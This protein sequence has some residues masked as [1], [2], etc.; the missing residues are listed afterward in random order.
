MLKKMESSE[1]KTAKP[2]WVPDYFID[3]I[4]D[5]NLIQLSKLGVKFVALDADS[6]LV[7]FRSKYLDQNVGKH[8]LSQA[9]SVDGICVASNRIIDLSKISD[10]L[11]AETVQ[12]TLFKRKP[13]AKFYKDVV[14]LFDA[15]PDEIAMVGDNLLSDIW[16][17]NRYGLVTVWLRNRTGVS[18]TTDKYTPSKALQR[19]LVSRYFSNINSKN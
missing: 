13:M 11:K 6:T 19:N 10:F 4:F 2:Y 9:E 16:G 1:K 15:R 8:I 5:L 18:L 3:S 17:A 12:A 7:P 14:E